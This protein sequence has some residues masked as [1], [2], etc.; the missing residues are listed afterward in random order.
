MQY[1][2]PEDKKLRVMRLSQELSEFVQAN[3][4][5]PEDGSKPYVAFDPVSRR[6][7]I[8]AVSASLARVN[9][10]GYQPIILCVSQIR[11]LVH[12][13]I[14]REMPGVVV[15]SD[16]EIFAAGHSVSVEIV[17]EITGEEE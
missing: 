16:M 15:L 8:S 1:A 13:A 5:R 17:D 9:D 6:K 7:W 12:S 14:E 2:D 10:K 4:Y 3:E 11:Q